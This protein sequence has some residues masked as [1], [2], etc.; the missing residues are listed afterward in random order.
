MLRGDVISRTFESTS[1][2]AIGAGLAV[3][4]DGAATIQVWD[5]ET[6]APLGIVYKSDPVNPEQHTVALSGS[7]V[8]AVAGETLAPGTDFFLT[9][10]QEGKLVAAS[11][12]E[13][14]VAVLVGTAG[15][16]ED[17]LVQVQVLVGQLAQAGG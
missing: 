5:D 8:W 14:Y 7:I 15:G 4:Q 16:D 9:T 17:D 3:A 12:G 10:D 2:A 11:P 6:Q 13:Y 1:G